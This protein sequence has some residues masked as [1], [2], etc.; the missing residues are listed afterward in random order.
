TTGPTCVR[1]LP[2]IVQ[3]RGRRIQFF[4]A[5]NVRSPPLDFSTSANTQRECISTVSAAWPEV[6]DLC[7]PPA[8]H[9]AFLG[10]AIW[11][12][13]AATRPLAR[14]GVGWLPTPASAAR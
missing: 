1:P 2:L 11:R 7:G 13:Q 9:R 12:R 10:P 6:V 14:A 3:G 8:R 5:G 4:S